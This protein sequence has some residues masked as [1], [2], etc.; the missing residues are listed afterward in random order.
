MLLHT[1]RIND[2]IDIYHDHYFAERYLT[3]DEFNYLYDLL[4]KKYEFSIP[5]AITKDI[6][7]IQLAGYFHHSS[8]DF[9]YNDSRYYSYEFTHS[10]NYPAIIKLYEKDRD[11][12]FVMRFKDKSVVNRYYVELFQILGRKNL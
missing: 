11:F 1:K 8:D 2:G 3:Q 4:G 9:Y 12:I 10:L 6:I 5:M 7:Y